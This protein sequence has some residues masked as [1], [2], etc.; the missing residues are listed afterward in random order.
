MNAKARKQI[1]QLREQ[2]EQIKA[3]FED[4]QQVEEEKLENVPEALREGDAA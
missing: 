1:G 2:L 4:L 3:Q